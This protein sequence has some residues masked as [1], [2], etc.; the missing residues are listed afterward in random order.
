MDFSEA[1]NKQKEGQEIHNRTIAGIHL[2]VTK[3]GNPWTDFIRDIP[4]PQ[5]NMGAFVDDHWKL[6]E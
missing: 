1:W 4:E 2:R 5:R 3:T 6:S